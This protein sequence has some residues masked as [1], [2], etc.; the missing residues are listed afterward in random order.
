MVFGLPNIPDKDATCEGCIYGKM[1]RLP[2]PKAA[3]RA[4]S[5]LELVHADIC[6]PTQTPSLNDNRYF[7]LFVDDN[8]RM[9]WVYVLKNKSEAFPSFLEF[10][11]MVENQSGRKIQTLRTDRGGEFIGKAFL[12]YCK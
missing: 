2:F 1:H 12:D 4:K 5:P 6:G 11:A 9:M 10:K 7:H 3:Y 8:T